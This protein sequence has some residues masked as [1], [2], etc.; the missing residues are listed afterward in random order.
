MQIDLQET[1]FPSPYQGCQMVCFQLKKTNWGKFCMA[2]ELKMLVYYMIIWNIL[3]PYGILHGHLVTLRKFVVV[4][5][6]VARFFFV[7]TYQNRKKYTK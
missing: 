3:L 7:Q 4:F 1:P 2:L 5:S 6:M